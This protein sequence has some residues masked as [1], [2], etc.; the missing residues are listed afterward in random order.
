MKLINRLNQ[1]Q[2][3]HATLRRCKEMASSDAPGVAWENQK[4]DI[5]LKEEVPEKKSASSPIKFCQKH[6]LMEN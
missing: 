5:S 1:K 4:S 2:N 6:R 3:C